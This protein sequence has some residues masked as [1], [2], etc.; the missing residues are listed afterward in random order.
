[1]LTKLEQTLY[2]DIQAKRPVGFCNLC[3]GEI[4]EKNGLCLRCERRRL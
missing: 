1:M 3:G 2:I 4:Y